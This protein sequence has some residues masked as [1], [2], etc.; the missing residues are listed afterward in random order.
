MSDLRSGDKDAM[1]Y[2]RVDGTGAEITTDGT[3]Q[4]VVNSASIPCKAFLIQV[5]AETPSSDFDIDVDTSCFRFSPN[6]SGPGLVCPKA[7]Y[8][9]QK[10]VPVQ[11][12]TFNGTIGY[13]Q[14]PTGFKV[15]VNLLN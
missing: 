12:G 15:L 5:Q 3:W 9:L 13:V 14:A 10:K 11:D 1:F 7:G 8:V 4:K 6:T 2:A